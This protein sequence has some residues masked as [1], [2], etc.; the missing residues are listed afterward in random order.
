MNRTTL[1][2]MIAA[3]M[4]GSGVAGYLIGRPIE[5]ADA[6]RVATPA[7][8]PAPAPAAPPA[9]T[10]VTTPA[11]PAPS[12]APSQANATAPVPLPQPPAAPDEPFAYRRITLDNSRPESEA[13]L[14]FNRPLASGG[15]NYGDFVTIAPEVK[16]ALR[17]VDDKL[18]VGGLAYGE[19][20]KVRLRSGFPGR[21]GVKLDTDQ[22]VEVAL[23]A[24]PAVVTLPGRGF[25]LPRGSAAG[26]PITTVNVSR[27]GLAVYRVNE[28]AINGFAS[29][30]YDATYPGSAPVTE[31]WSLYGWLNGTNG[32]LQWRGT[33]EVRNVANQPVTT[34]F[35]I[36]ETVKDWKPGSYFVVAWD[37]AQPPPRNYDDDEGRG[38][39]AGM[40]VIDT[41]IALTTF[42][43]D[44]GLN[45]FAR[46]LQTAQPMAGLE[47]V[48]L[49]RGNEPMA[50]AVTDAAGRVL[51][52]AGLLKGRGAARPAAVMASNAAQQDFTRLELG[53]A[54]F[55]F[56]DRGVTG[57]DQPGPVDAFLYTERGVYRPGETVQL[58]TLLR[59]AGAVA[60]TNLP[61]TLVVKRPD[62]SEFTRFT[63]PPAASGAVH[64][65]IALPKSSRRGR[66]SVAAHVDPKAPP[67][68]TVE[69]S[70][71]DFVP[72]KLK[73]EL[74][75]AAPLV[76][77]SQVN[78]FDVKADFLYGAPGANLAVEGD[79]RITVDAEPFPAYARYSFGSQ[80]ARKD[81]EPPFLTLKAPDTDE[82]G[83]TRFEWGGD[84]KDTDLPLRAQ[85]V[86]RVFEPGG[87]RATKA[88]LALP[89]RTRDVYLGIRPTFEGRYAREGVETA[90]DLVA[91]DASG[92]PVARPGVEYRIERI[93]WNYQW[94]EVDGR[95]RWQSI[96]NDRLITADTVAFKADGPTRLSFRL[97]W[98]S[99]RL[100]VIDRQ[101][102]TTTTLPFYVGWYGGSDDGEETPDTLR[103]ASDKQA[104]APGE[105]ARL[106]IEAPFAGEALLAIATDRVISTRNV[107]VPAGGT[108]IEVP[109]SG[110]WGPGAYALVTAWR[111]LD[112]PADRVPTRAIGLAWLGLE[113]K[114]R[115]L[116]VKIE[117]PDKI[118]PRQK[119]EVPV[120]VA[121]LGGEEAW[122][123]L[124]AVDEGILQLTRFKTPD[125]AAFYLGKRRLGVAMRD[126]YGRLLD[127][128]ADD[129]GRI[130]VGGDAGEIGG[131]DVVPTRTVALFSGAVKLDDKGEA[132]IALEV[133]DFI[134]QLRVMVVAYAKSRVGSADKR[135]FVRD[136]V[137]ADA[138]LPR[139]L[140]PDD[141]GRLA[142]SLHNVDGAAGD[143]RLTVQASGA[144]SLDRPVA[145]TRRLASG[146]RELLTWPLVA[147]SDA[148][149]GK[150][151]VE[152][153]GPG[154]FAVRREWDIQVR[155]AQTPSAVDTVSQLAAG[156]ELTLDRNVI[157]EFAP[158]TAQVG[159]S[160]TRVPGI[161]VAA[162]LRALDKYP[163]GCIE[164][165]T[166]RALPLLYYNDVALL[167][168]G[169][170]DPRIPDRVQE[171]VYRIVDM[172]LPDG[173][174]GMWGPWT[175][176]AEWLQA[177][178]L[179]FLLRARDQSMAVPAAP[180]QR[181]LGWMNRNADKFTPNAQAYAW[182]VLARAGLADP[183]RVRYF[184]DKDGAN[185]SDGL[186]WAQL[187]AALN[188]VAEPGRAR[189]AFAK[190]RDMAD[191]VGR[192]D[193]YGSA[194]RNRAALL[195]LAAEA[196]GREGFAQVASIVGEKLAANV[197]QT[198]T[199]E[200]AWLVL[201][202]RAMSGAGGDLVYALDGERKTAPRDPV[203]INP[204]AAAIARGVRLR[205][206]GDG[207]VWLQV[208]A[209]GVPREALPATTQGI[210]VQREFLT[211]S[212]RPADLRRLRQNE[213]LIVSISGRN[214]AGGYHEVALL[215]LLPAGFEIEAVL[216]EETAKPFGFLAKLSDTRIAEARDDRFFASF[217]LGR[218]PYRSWWDSEEELKQS[219]NGYHVAYI[220]RAVTPGAF[221]LPAV[222]VSD[223][224]APRV[225]G[226]TAMGRVEIAPR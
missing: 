116:D 58:V 69:F 176:A 196:G 37:A 134:G 170:S 61:V 157:A 51:F 119:I 20:Y 4:L 179:D 158:G 38:E 45:V 107:T 105:T 198:T 115:T 25:I 204:D 178:A 43:G 125:P 113:P 211:L 24:R 136:A 148:G 147:S 140:A 53:K 56:S 216:N 145:E 63:Q 59:D 106:R 214:V 49:S 186:A 161:D 121:N 193:Y 46:S 189:L 160:L 19:T 151:A 209:R 82:A 118:V 132:K 11:A 166:S 217:S 180:L 18:C 164:Q 70:V 102:D 72:E 218:R 35:P 67:V 212:G 126:D 205:N 181:A 21:D 192:G 223:M 129:L 139:F 94:Y 68:G 221:A 190:A 84:L 86:A 60:L 7:T 197:N 103:V 62:G 146:Q 89:V 91:V 73:V 177:Y 142:L 156:R 8:P 93:D 219:V 48:L 98:G 76:R 33:M 224:Y 108:T 194:L 187:A 90:F 10:P 5:R 39:A 12:Q 41:D 159:V 222:N 80:Q 55:D 203:T 14:A 47:V 184:Q 109:V 44:D 220:V 195:A 150:V 16:T 40:W 104:Y 154:N 78:T 135:V 95:W 137:T 182:Y 183:G 110:D 75:S 133:P 174:F 17:V 155:P 3:L 79:L 6:P 77:P 101:A 74:S 127:T 120:K 173:S 15:V 225:H 114:L 168:Y 81:F 207:A 163:F 123:T 2:A 42:T 27:V 143:Y 87:G 144:V 28:R 206:E 83:R 153:S 149:F 138:V 52:A 124:A 34:A 32:A 13:C 117:A 128:R 92:K 208:T 226:R 199:Q 200:Q 191:A 66:W 100:T 29:D 130:R 152:V 97:G 99:H 31:S 64:Q 71:E 175:P 122:V 188:Q 36:R 30:R 213:R 22:D 9:T 26:L 172:Q 185:I 96:A 210:S 202:A 50:K 57:R 141:R 167:G 215:D 88:D 85:L 169:P 112:K 162:L 111:P 23:G 131:L 65:P 54:P 201:A 165:T 1:L 171:A